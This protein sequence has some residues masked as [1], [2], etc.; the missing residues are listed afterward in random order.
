MRDTPDDFQFPINTGR[1]QVFVEPPR[2][3]IKN[4]L[5]LEMADKT[6]D[7]IL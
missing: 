6:T 1:P 3:E 2:L 5:I 7:T 4:L